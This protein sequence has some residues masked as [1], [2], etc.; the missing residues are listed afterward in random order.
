MTWPKL[1]GLCP[2]TNYVPKSSELPWCLQCIVNFL[3]KMESQNQPIWK[4]S[5]K[6]NSNHNF[7]SHEAR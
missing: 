1:Y 5:S 4:G 3:T 6:A 2:I 7:F